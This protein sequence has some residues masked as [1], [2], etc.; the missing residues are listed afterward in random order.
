ML[1]Q[2][3]VKI[4]FILFKNYYRIH[5]VYSNKSVK[6]SEICY[7]KLKMEYVYCPYC[8]SIVIF[9]IGSNNIYLKNKY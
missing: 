7:K 3:H 5:I 6:T 8:N 1:N 2:I 9:N 4:I